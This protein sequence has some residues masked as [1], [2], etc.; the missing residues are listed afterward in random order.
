MAEQGSGVEAES[1]VQEWAR[2]EPVHLKETKD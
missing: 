1:G 2:V